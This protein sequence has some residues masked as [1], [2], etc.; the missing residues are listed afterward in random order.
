MTVA[1]IVFCFF[2]PETN[3]RRPPRPPASRVWT[4]T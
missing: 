1:F 3:A 2:F 4:V